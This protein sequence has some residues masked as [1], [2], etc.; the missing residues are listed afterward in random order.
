MVKAGI[1][2]E[3]TKR[4]VKLTAKVI[5]FF[6]VL[7]LLGEGISP[8]DRVSFSWSAVTGRMVE[9]LGMWVVIFCFSWI[10]FRM[11]LDFSKTEKL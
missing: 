8:K 4:A 2:L 7:N 3:A 5:L 6:L 9:S 11:Y 10:C 1:N